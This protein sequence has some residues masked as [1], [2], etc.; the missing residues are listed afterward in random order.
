MSSVISVT[1]AL[2]K[3]GHTVLSTSTVQF[4]R[5]HTVLSLR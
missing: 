4:C 2:W 5:R 3:F 1:R